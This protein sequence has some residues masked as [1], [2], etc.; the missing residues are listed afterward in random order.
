MGAVA[1]LARIRAL[2]SAESKMRKA[3]IFFGLLLLLHSPVCVQ[4]KRALEY[5]TD[6][7]W[8]QWKR[9]HEKSYDDNLTELERYVTWLSNRALV[10][11]H[12]TLGKEFGYTLA[13]NQFADMVRFLQ[14]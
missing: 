3:V 10:E 13:L 11:G 6:A 14:Y 8:L 12:N 4:S 1:I 5:K 2:C 7:D 9:R